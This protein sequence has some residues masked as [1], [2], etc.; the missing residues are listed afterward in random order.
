MKTLKRWFKNLIWLFNHPP[1][2][3]RN[4]DNNP[5]CD[6]CGKSYLTWNFGNKT[7]CLDCL[8]ETI[9]KVNKSKKQLWNKKNQKKQELS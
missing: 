6:F 1:I 9:K 4:C 7:F 3:I 5:V 2:N 8:Y